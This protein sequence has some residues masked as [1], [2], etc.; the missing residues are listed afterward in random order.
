MGEY[1][2]K[3]GKQSWRKMLSITGSKRMLEEISD[4]E[5]SLKDFIRKRFTEIIIK[6]I[7]K[8]IWDFRISIE[9]M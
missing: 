7:I 1:S 2:F 3:N 9:P 8:R 6:A 5:M 4:E